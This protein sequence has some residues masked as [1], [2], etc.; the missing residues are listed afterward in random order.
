MHHLPSFVSQGL[1]EH[2]T[3]RF[4][5]LDE[6]T[7]NW[8]LTPSQPLRSYQGYSNIIKKIKIKIKGMQQL[9][10]DSDKIRKENNFI[11]P[12]REIIVLLNQ[13]QTH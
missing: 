5:I 13:T 1:L 8:L 3:P 2:V 6:G 4:D 9:H 10:S 12:Q 7:D 11:H